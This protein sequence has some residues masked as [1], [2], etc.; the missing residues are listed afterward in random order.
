LV[1]HVQYT[2]MSSPGGRAKRA[3]TVSILGKVRMG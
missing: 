2:D 1:S 3:K